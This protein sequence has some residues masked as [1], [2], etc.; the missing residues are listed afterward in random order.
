M[1]KEPIVVGGNLGIQ[2]DEIAFGGYDQGI[3]LRLRSFSR[4]RR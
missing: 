2:A 4:N 1:A 3:D